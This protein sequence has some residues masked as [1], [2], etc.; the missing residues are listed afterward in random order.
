MMAMG[1]CWHGSSAF[2]FLFNLRLHPCSQGGQSLS[3]KFL[4]LA[5]RRNIF[6]GILNTIQE[7][8]S[9]GTQAQLTETSSDNVFSQLMLQRG[10]NGY[11]FSKIPGRGRG[12]TFFR[13]LETS[14]SCDFP[15]GGGAVR[16]LCPSRSAHGTDCVRIRDNNNSTHDTY[17]AEI[18]LHYNHYV[19]PSVHCHLMK[20]LNS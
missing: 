11:L 6:T 10:S 12:P 15:G 3:L 8:S 2:V 7:C 19:S 1:K 16:T 18:G 13:P 4:A 17:L 20:M 5:G 9:G 14:R